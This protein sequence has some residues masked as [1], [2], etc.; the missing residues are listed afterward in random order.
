MG[1]TTL[2]LRSSASTSPTPMDATLIIQCPR[3][4][5]GRT[6]ATAGGSAR[7]VNGAGKAGDCWTN[8]RRKSP[9]GVAERAALLPT[10]EADDTGKH[11]AV[12]TPVP[13]TVRPN[14][15]ES[16]PI[17]DNVRGGKGEEE[18]EE[19]ETLKAAGTATVSWAPASL[20]LL[21]VLPPAT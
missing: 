9:P 12:D 17:N 2:P 3:S 4:V 10:K 6:M 15:E 11:Q 1:V 18:V 19:E 5:V 20:S 16:L 14:D 21:E 13:P 7:P 8:T